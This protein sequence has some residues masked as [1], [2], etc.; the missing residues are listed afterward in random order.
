MT[1]GQRAEPAIAVVIP[2]YQRAG[3]VVRAVESALSGGDPAVEVAVADDASTD[4][5]A[6]VLGGIDD[7]RFHLTVARSHANG[8]VAR[9]AG[10]ALTTAPIIAFLDS[11]DVFLPGRLDR[12]RG[13]FAAHPD[14]D[15]VLDGFVVVEGGR[16]EE[17]RHPTACPQPGEWNELLLAHAL[18]LTCSAIAVRR[19]ALD[20][21]GGF[22]PTLTRHQDRDLLMRLTRAHRVAVGSGCDVVKYQSADSFSR[23]SK[24]YVA[25]LDAFT[26]RHPAL[27][28]EAHRDLLAY[29]IARGILRPLL[30]GR[31][32]AAIGEGRA[33][34]RA[35]TLPRGLFAAFLRY[36]RGKV[37]RRRL[38]N[39]FARGK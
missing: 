10:L 19:E 28:D 13:Y 9:N 26:A 23:K 31:F 30:A 22:D 1:G 24:D 38:A 36:P 5:T 25:G 4:G 3:P 21:V 35:T 32:A 15:A 17:V 12:L 29:L 16:R 8:N 39:A 37:A 33:L 20:A 14:V 11:D 27:L 7:P 34:A 6:E 18:P 2:T